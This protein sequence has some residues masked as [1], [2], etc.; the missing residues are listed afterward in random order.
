MFL[1][2]YSLLRSDISFPP[3]HVDC[4]Y[5]NDKKMTIVFR[6]DASFVYAPKSSLCVAQEVEPG[7]FLIEDAFAS[8]DCTLAVSI[9]TLWSRWSGIGGSSRQPWEGIYL[10]FLTRSPGRCACVMRGQRSANALCQYYG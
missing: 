3:V 2:T 5:V 6:G 1:C 8:R 7:N 10:E 4:G 9:L